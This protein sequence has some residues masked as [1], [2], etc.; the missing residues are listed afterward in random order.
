MPP[1]R[2]RVTAGPPRADVLRLVLAATAVLVGAA[3]T[4]VVVLALPD[5]M[6]GVGLSA[7][8][9]QLGAP[10]ISAFLLGYVCVLPLAGRASDGV[11]RVPVLIACLLAFAVG[12]LVTASSESLAVAVLGR[13]IQGLGAGGL[14]PPT[15]ALVADLWPAERRGLPLGAV[16]AAQELGSVV[17]PLAGA[18]VLAAA[19]WRTIF[20]VNLALALVLAVALLPRPDRWGRAP[21]ALL[22]AG[23]IA[24]VGLALVLRPPGWF[25]ADLRWGQALI[26]LSGTSPWAS[27]LAL[28]T[29]ALAA[30]V[31]GACLARAWPALRSTG[32]DAPG[33]ALLAVSLA[34]VVLI[35]AGAE[36]TRSPVDD[37]WPLYLAVSV[38]AAAGFAAR[39][40]TAAD[41]LVPRAALR[42]RG[43]WG[44]VL[45][46]MLIGAALVAVLVDVPVFARATRYPESQLGAALVLVQ[47]LAALPVGA[48][49]GGWAANRVQPRL[50]A[51]AGMLLAALGLAGMTRWEA[52]ALPGAAS[53]AVLLAAGLGFGLAIAPVN[54]VLLATTRDDV[55]GVA[56]ALVVLA[57]T[58]GML[59]GLSALTAVGLRVFYARQAGIG[60]PF[61]LCPRTPTDCPAFVEATRA[62]VLGELQ[63]I[64]AGA[65]VLALA[66]AV[67]CVVLLRVPGGVRLP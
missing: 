30:L 13:G 64:F 29:L 11:G 24:T 18:L 14:V 62:S 49:A 45:V 38:L 6:A 17:G 52:D 26:P 16:G 28:G 39:Q 59:V 44:S 4:Y 65:G 1:V 33:A 36:T 20:W 2:D 66:A 32:I 25:A 51:G 35:F 19:G 3:D 61:T 41:P 55:H 63:A 8:Q 21:S 31:L 5:M 12:S 40:R 42:H 54:A 9:L 37:R 67:L 47:F 23:G 53:T 56:S 50:V 22:A 48:L 43:A 27:P 57:R 58:V 34:G 10:L 7:E 60:T 15:L 46:S